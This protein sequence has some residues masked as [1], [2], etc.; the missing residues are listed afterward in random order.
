MASRQTARTRKGKANTE[1]KTR[2]P[3]RVYHHKRR[4]Y[5]RLDVDSPIKFKQFDPYKPDSTMDEKQLSNGRIL[6][7]SGGGVLLETDFPINEDDFVMME[8]TLCQT[9][10]LSGIIGK[11]KRVDADDSE[12]KPLVGVEFM[13]AEQ[14]REELPEEAIK[15]MG[16]DAFSFDEQIRKMLLKHVFAHKLREK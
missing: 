1:Q 8:F 5:I 13:T 6:N 16:D 11:V 14:L 10:K 3:F 15:S 9:E 12:E 2:K 7:I 4:R